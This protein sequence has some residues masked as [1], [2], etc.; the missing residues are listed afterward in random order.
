MDLL[1]SDEK[2]E[3][4]ATFERVFAK[5]SS[6]T[7]VRQAEPIGFDP[8]LWSTMVELG[9]PSM[10]IPLENGGGGADLR[11][12]CAVAEVAGH[13]LA[14]VPLVESFVASRVLAACGLSVADLELSLLSVAIRPAYDGIA[15][16][17]P[18][19]AVA[20]RIVALDGDELVLVDC[21]G[22]RSETPSNLGCMP[23][24]DVDLR[25]GTRRVLSSGT[26]AILAFDAFLAEW[27]V[28]TSAMRVGV[29]SDALSIGVAY[30][31]ERVQFGVPIGSFQA[32]AHRF[33]DDFTSIEGARLLMYEAAWALDKADERARSLAAMSFL[34]AA[35]TAQRS[36]SDSLHFHGGYGFMLEYDIQLH[37]RRAKAWSLVS[38]DVPSAYDRLGGLLYGS[39]EE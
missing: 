23:V 21:E 36:A 32:V 3:V 5:E 31:K 7:A 8:Q 33:A 24:A 13:H 1:H 9:V 10:G 20:D 14:S 17:A 12:L 29:A 16:L 18:A 25:R 34:F 28:L 38:G 6:P 19:G 22:A 26:Q 27:Q 4:S 2:L 37:Y 39:D 11:T 30:A 35:E 15:R